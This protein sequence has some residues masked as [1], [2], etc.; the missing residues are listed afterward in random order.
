MKKF[1]LPIMFVFCIFEIGFAFDS[2]LDPSFGAVGIV[3]ANVGQK[4]DQPANLALQSDGKI[5]QVGWSMDEYSNRRHDFALIRYNSNG[6]LD[7]SFGSNGKVS[8]AIGSNTDDWARMPAIQSGGKIVVAGSTRDNPNNYLGWD[9]V[10]VRYD[11]DGSL[12]TSF[13]SNGKVVVDVNGQ[14]NADGFNDLA[15][16]SSGKIIAVGYTYPGSNRFLIMRFNTDGSIDSTFGTNGVVIAHFSTN[17]LE[18][19]TSVQVL[20]DDTIVVAGSGFRRP[21]DSSGWGFLELACRGHS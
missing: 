19:A 3:K 16:Q 21:T 8:T 1:L 5:V 14:K 20:D 6:S 7:A 12:D 18:D 11:P 17:T 2:D 9:A 13:G 15:F 4:V 10:L